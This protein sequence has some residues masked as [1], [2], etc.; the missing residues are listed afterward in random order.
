[1]KLQEELKTARSSLRIV[2]GDLSNE[3][4]RSSKREQEAFAARYQIV[5]VQEDL[6]NVTEKLKLMEQERDALK[7]LVKN[8]EIARIAAEGQIPLPRSLDGE[9]AS[10]RKVTPLSRVEVL[11]S[12]ASEEEIEQLR[13]E[14]NWE[15][16]KAENAWDQVEFMQMEC[17]FKC[18]SCKHAESKG[19][20]FV[21]LPAPEAS[22]SLGSLQSRHGASGSQDEKIAPMN[23][24]L[25]PKRSTIFIPSEGVFRSITPAPEESP[26]ISPAKPMSRPQPI[27]LSTVT[28]PVFNAPEPRQNLYARTPSCEPPSTAIVPDT[29][30]SLASLLSYNPNAQQSAREPEASDNDATQLQD[31]QQE[32][33]EDAT[34]QQI[35]HTISTTTRI[36]LALPNDITPTSNATHPTPALPVSL[37]PALSP[38]MT[39][40]EALAM[41]RERRGRARSL[42]QGTLTPRK[43]MVEG[44]ARRDISAP[45]VRSG[46][47]RGRQAARP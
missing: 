42:A 39:R 47:V 24:D 17:Q 8:E 40:E 7:T 46:A 31:E 12:A 30:A 5:G 29:R 18:C 21:Y 38:T 41:I 37:D 23:F 32:E 4:E 28:V 34:P 27:S 33:D 36:P 25:E 14:L 26:W 35:F 13:E 22:K 3:K 15:R 1:M 6:A 10:P 44:G 16:R 2:Q 20:E 43:Q 19:H 11:S 45:A 9:F